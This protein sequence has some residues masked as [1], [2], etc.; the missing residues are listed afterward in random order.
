MALRKRRRDYGLRGPG[1]DL[2][3]RERVAQRT[4]EVSPGRDVRLEHA[5][6]DCGRDIAEELLAPA[7]WTLWRGLE[8]GVEV[9]PFDDVASVHGFAVGRHR[10]RTEHAKDLRKRFWRQQDRAVHRALACSLPEIER[11]TGP[12]RPLGGGIDVGQALRLSALEN[13]ERRRCRAMR[14]HRL[15]MR[16]QPAVD[17][18]EPLESDVRAIGREEAERA[19]ETAGGAH[20]R[21]ILGQQQVPPWSVRPKDGRDRLGAGCGVV[22]FCPHDGESSLQLYTGCVQRAEQPL[23]GDGIDGTGSG[24]DARNTCSQRRSQRVDGGDAAGEGQIVGPWVD[25]YLECVDQLL[26]A[27]HEVAL[28]TPGRRRYRR[29]APA[30]AVRRCR[31]V[32]ARRGRPLRRR[33]DRARRWQS[34]G[35]PAPRRR[36]RPASSPRRRPALTELPHPPVRPGEGTAST[37]RRPRAAARQPEQ[38]RPVAS[39]PRTRVVPWRADRFAPLGLKRPDPGLPHHVRTVTLVR[40]TGGNEPKLGAVAGGIEQ[41]VEIN[42][43]RAATPAV[44]SSSARSPRPTTAAS[45]RLT[46]SSTPSRAPALTRSSSRPTSPRPRA[47]RREPWRVRFSPQDAHPVRLLAAHGVHGGAVGAASREHA[48]ERGPVFL[49]SPFSIEAVDLLDAIGVRSVED[50]VRRGRQPRAAR[51]RWLPTGAPV[52]LS[53]GMSPL[54]ELDAAVERVRADGVPTSRCCS[55]PRRIRAR[56]SGSA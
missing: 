54:A 26:R 5:L 33:P 3:P 22:G 45:A 53:S 10:H 12:D 36:P 46:R 31:D 20:L 35:G 47:R 27:R 28:W 11:E 51:A 29:A 55:A 6:H 16:R 19:D 4:H 41:D 18:L 25:E 52:L 44:V 1:N 32:A 2:P 8:V 23:S 17:V 24:V 48:E 42:V 49:S 43:G 37:T 39:D 40:P 15:R 14:H 21:G 9:Q 56:R 34:R 50:R 38:R 30:S 7:L 13:R